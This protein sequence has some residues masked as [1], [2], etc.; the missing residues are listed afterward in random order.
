[1][2]PE[3]TKDPKKA[4]FYID[5]KLSQESIYLIGAYIRLLKSSGYKHETEPVGFWE[6]PWLF[7]Y[8]VVN[9][10]NRIYFFVNEIHGDDDS[11]IYHLHADWNEAAEL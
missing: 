7:R 1:M 3:N 10:K 9:R 4:V 2:P 11:P 5:V 6:N 8:L